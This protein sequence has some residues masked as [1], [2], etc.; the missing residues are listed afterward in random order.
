M[1]VKYETLR[2]K[3]E[4]S[5]MI[6]KQKNKEIENNETLSKNKTNIEFT[7]NILKKEN[8]DLNISNWQK[9]S[10][11]AKLKESIQKKDNIVSK[12]EKP[13]CKIEEVQFGT[14]ENLW[15]FRI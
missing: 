15:V 14:R 8:S 5:E 3:L 13:E 9:D 11:I 6:I 2:E 7:M 1:I 10:D 4:E 12:K